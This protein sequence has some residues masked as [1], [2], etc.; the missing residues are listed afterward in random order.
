M[1]GLLRFFLVLT[2]VAAVF[3][4][5]LGSLLLIPH[6]ASYLSSGVSDCVAATRDANKCADLSA[7]GAVGDMFGAI[8]A[9]FSGLALGAIALTLWVESRSRRESR[10]P[11]VLGSLSRE[12]GVEAFRPDVHVEGNPMSIKFSLG[13]QNQT[14]DAALNVLAKIKIRTR[15]VYCTLSIDEP[16]LQ[17]GVQEMPIELK[18]RDADL[19]YFLSELTARRSVDVQII[20]SYRSLE[21]VNWKT[22]VVYELSCR[23]G[24]RDVQLLNS[25]RDDTWRDESGWPLGATVGIDFKIKSGSWDHRLN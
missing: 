13:L 4:I 16:L 12:G 6:I 2:A 1:S 20:T 21:G 25:V 24:Q 3:G 15:A 17:G 23:A 14:T 5:W 9:L 10:K 11:L 7:F 22:E 8:N 19:D 18:L